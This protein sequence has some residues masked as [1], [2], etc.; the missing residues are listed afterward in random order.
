MRQLIFRPTQQPFL[1]SKF[2]SRN[3]KDWK[4]KRALLRKEE[5]RR[6]KTLSNVKFQKDL[7]SEATKTSERKVVFNFGT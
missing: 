7:L 3:A 4:L 2:T 5:P 1:A 6:A